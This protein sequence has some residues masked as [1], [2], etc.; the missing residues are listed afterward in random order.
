MIPNERAMPYRAFNTC[1]APTAID[2]SGKKIKYIAT[3]TGAFNGPL[4]ANVREN[5]GS[6]QELAE[7]NQEV[8][9]SIKAKAGA[10]VR[11]GSVTGLA[12]LVGVERKLDKGQ[13]AQ[14]S[15]TIAKDSQHSH[16][17]YNLGVCVRG[18]VDGGDKVGA[19]ASAHSNRRQIGNVGY[20]GQLS[21][22]DQE[23]GHVLV[24]PI[25]DGLQIADW[26]TQEAH[27]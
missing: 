22:Q 20:P 14:K 26:D 8:H 23:A 16:C 13:R 12:R 4:P 3:E 21:E 10:E 2:I 27:G 24:P 18:L 11:L 9:E 6:Q 17:T 5:V 7:S 25:M 1:R 19:I 15:H